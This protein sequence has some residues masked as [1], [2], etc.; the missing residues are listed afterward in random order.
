[1]CHQSNGGLRLGQQRTA[2]ILVGKIADKGNGQIRP[3]RGPCCRGNTFP[4]HIGKNGTD[5]FSGQ[6]LRDSPANAVARA[7]YKSCFARGIE[8]LV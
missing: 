4:V 1:M 5:A 3:R 2:R 6:S 8:W 7:G